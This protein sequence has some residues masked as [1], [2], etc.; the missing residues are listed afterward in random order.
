M[1]EL[2]HYYDW[3]TGSFRISGRDI[4]FATKQGMPFHG[5]DDPAACLLGENVTL[6]PEA[7][8]V[9]FFDCGSGT[10][11]AGICLSHGNIAATLT[12]RNFLCA[13]AA[14]RTLGLNGLAGEVAFS[15]GSVGLS[16][17][18]PA[19][20]VVIR[21]PKG[22]AAA[23][24]LLWDASF[25]LRQGGRCFLAGGNNEG[26]K[27]AL[28]RMG[29]LFGPVEV[30][31]YKGGNRV[32]VAVK[33]SDQPPQDC[34]FDRQWCDHAWFAE[35]DAAVAGM[36]IAVRSRPG[37]FAW[38][39]MDEGS[40]LL[41]ENMSLA[42]S[43]QVLDL[44]CGHGL[45]G[46]AAAIRAPKG[47]T[48]M[49]DCDYEAIRCAEKTAAA[50]G[51]TNCTVLPSDALGAVAGRKFDAVISNPPFH[52]G[53]KAEL[54]IAQQFIAG[55]ARVL[56]PGGNM[57]LVANRTLPYEDIFTQHFGQ[58]ATVYKDRFFKVLKG[59]GPL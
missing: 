31:A 6:P 54:G 41:I 29:E 4:P 55:A 25:A 8:T 3:S 28:A 1:H 10:A 53:H 44:G 22:R 5:T 52:A 7:A 38:D 42:E 47:H 33:L 2:G 35:F 39:R 12:D 21:L 27:P 32:G 17:L 19:D 58:V 36:S 24:Q 48:V 59:T 26:I 30:I 14:R 49:V 46:V 16:A 11:A 15:H 43:D 34:R 18:P 37:V 23:M 40:R 45:V 9:L 51:V 56:N 20:A 57:Q 13:E 50:N